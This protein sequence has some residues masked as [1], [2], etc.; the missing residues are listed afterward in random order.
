M[1]KHV[2]LRGRQV[3]AW[4]VLAMVSIAAIGLTGQ[5]LAADRKQESAAV[6]AVNS[7][8][9]RAFRESDIAAMDAVWGRKG[10]IAVQHPSGRTHRRASQRHAQLGSDPT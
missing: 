10:T 7:E 2:R 5:S 3:V 4:T 6:L 8:F 1:L 9:Y